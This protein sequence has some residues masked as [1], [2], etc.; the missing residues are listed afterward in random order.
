MGIL[1]VDDRD[2]SITYTGGWAQAASPNEFD[3][4]STFTA[5]AGSTAKVTFTGA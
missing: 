4:T 1:A 5:V 2:P 3:N